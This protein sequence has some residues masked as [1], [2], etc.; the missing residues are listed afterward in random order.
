MYLYSQDDEEE[1]KQQLERQQEASRLE[2]QER[3]RN[4]V[5]AAMRADN[6]WQAQEAATQETRTKN[7]VDFALLRNFPGYDVNNPVPT[8]R[9]H[10]LSW[11]LQMFATVGGTG[12]CENPASINAG[13]G[14]DSSYNLLGSQSFHN[15]SRSMD[16]SSKQNK[17]QQ[18]TGGGQLPVH[19]LA[20]SN[21]STCCCLA[22]R[23]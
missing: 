1:A 18:Y 3:R 15:T 9:E 14:A 19:V 20:S 5:A 21:V 4:M 12:T 13:V 10:P 2:E 6:K 16:P 11:R 23:R 8:T 17:K 22:L 7:L